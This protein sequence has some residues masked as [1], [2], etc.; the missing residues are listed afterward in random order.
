MLALLSGCPLSATA[1]GSPSPWSPKG[2]GIPSASQP[3]A[4]HIK[5]HKGKGKKKGRLGPLHSVLSVAKGSPSQELSTINVML[6]TLYNILNVEY[7]AAM[8]DT[9]P[10]SQV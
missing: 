10:G 5:P 9:N 2:G 3:K 6:A 4:A 8:T 1:T 7:E